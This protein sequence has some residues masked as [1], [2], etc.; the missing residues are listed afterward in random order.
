MG[1]IRFS[2]GLLAQFHDE[3]TTRY[4]TTGFEVHGDAGSL[5]G[6]DCM[7]HGPNGDVVLR[8]SAGEEGLYGFNFWT[9]LLSFTSSKAFTNLK[10]IGFANY[11]KLWTWTFQTDPPSSWYTAIVNMGVFGGLYVA[12][13]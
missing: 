4:A 2:N 12:S 3:F 6:R 13:A 1:V 11:Q 10:F 7:T 5:I 8:T 9:L